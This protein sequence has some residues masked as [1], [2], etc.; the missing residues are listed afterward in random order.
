V[1][2]CLLR[3]LHIGEVYER[4]VPIN[5]VTRFKGLKTSFSPCLS[6]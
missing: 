3:H 1:L 5:P 2:T 4:R 6:G